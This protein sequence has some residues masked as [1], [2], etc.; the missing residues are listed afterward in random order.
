LSLAYV[1]SRP[2]SIGR[3]I[4]CPFSDWKTLIAFLMTWHELV[5]MDYSS[6]PI[7][8]YTHSVS[9]LSRSHRVNV[10]RQPTV[11]A[12]MFLQGVCSPWAQIGKKCTVAML[13]M[14]IKS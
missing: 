7:I 12:S 2:L 8:F 10:S 6:F 4:M 9:Q 1:Q 13:G 11:S 5:R 3:S 14:W